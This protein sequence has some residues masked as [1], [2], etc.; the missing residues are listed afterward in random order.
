MAHWKDLLR[1]LYGPARGDE[2]ARALQRR[3]EAFRRAHPHLA[4]T[5]PPHERLTQRDAL[6][7]TYGDQFRAPGEPPLQ[8]LHRF[9]RDHLGR[10]ISGVHLLPFFPYSSDD[11]FSVIDYRR[12]DPKLGDWEDIDRLH[13]SFSLMFDLVLNHVS[14]RSEWFQ[15][16]LAG[17]PQFADWFI[18]VDPAV[19]TS[20]VV[21]PRS[22]PLLTPVETARGRRYVWTTFSPDQIDLNYA[23]PAVLTEM[24][25]ILLFY[26]ER[27][28]RIIRLDAIAYLWKT[29][30]TTC[31]H[32]PQTHE[33]VKLMRTI[34]DACAP[35]TLLLTETNVPHAE[36]IS[37]FGAG[38]EAHLVY[39]FSLPPLLLDGILHQ[40][41][42]ILQQWLSELQPPAAQTSFLNF[43]ASHDGIGVRP[44][45]GLV[46]P[47]RIEALVDH[48]R[49][50]GGLVS[51]RRTSDGS[52]A[53]YELNITYLDA[54]RHRSAPT[55][56][57]QIQPFLLSQAVML[58]LQGIP[59]VYFH[60]L[61][62]T[63]NDT[64]GARVSGQPRRI[65][66]RKYT[67][68]E[69]R[70]VLTDERSLQ[71]RVYQCYTDMLRKRRRIPGFHP[72]AS[73]S[74]VDAGDPRILAFC[75]GTESPMPVLV[76]ANLSSE[77]V[78]VERNRLPAQ[79]AWTYDR[80]TESSVEGDAPIR[81]GPYG[82]RWLT[83]T[84][85]EP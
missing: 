68:D 61:V 40:D 1:F 47:S 42:T 59:A 35:G 66:R 67:A 70:R 6:L 74:V 63:P 73:Q 76:L 25:D 83:S 4:D 85:Q 15:R 37:Y 26:V 38:D 14:S 71:R 34:L 81:L 57:E 12:V 84:P 19:D 23:N 44:L 51:T 80:L 48:V 8:T 72:D 32:L 9:L 64:E 52:E 31:I 60:S 62:G 54:L 21:R 29:I 77:A 3:L 46:P 82:V 33:V 39:Q 22:L 41:A 49:A 10:A 43:T 50:Q 24:I 5:P 78:L 45:E 28:A 69:L 27:G 16:Y 56:Q 30:G 17:D 11:G 58:A 65:N 36:N 75:R 13:E 2:A 7:I 53:P 18:E 79:H 55:A 20:Q